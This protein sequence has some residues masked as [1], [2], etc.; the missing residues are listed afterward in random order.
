MPIPPGF[1]EADVSA[2]FELGIVPCISVE[3]AERAIINPIKNSTAERLIGSSI[4][5][6]ML[7][8]ALLI[9]G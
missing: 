6:V 8:T 4:D 9:Q 2:T 7:N 3:Q 5:R 1:E